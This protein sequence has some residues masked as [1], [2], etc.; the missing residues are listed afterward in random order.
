[1]ALGQPGACLAAAA[2]LETRSQ[3][4]KKGSREKRGRLC[5][6][7]AEPMY[8][9]AQF[10]WNLTFGGSLK[11]NPER[12]VPCYGGRVCGMTSHV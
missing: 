11:G 5:L 7:G 8:P 1:M 3:K 2:G 12:Q 10:T 6:K 9:P 4:K